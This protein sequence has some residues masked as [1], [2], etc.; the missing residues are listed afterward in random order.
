[1]LYT[2]KYENFVINGPLEGREE[3]QDVLGLPVIDQLVAA[4]CSLLNAFQNKTNK[5][6]RRTTS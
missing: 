6:R 3:V 2:L 4:A 1:M 5:R